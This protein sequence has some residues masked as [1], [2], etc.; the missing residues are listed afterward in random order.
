MFVLGRSTLLCV[1]FTY[2]VKLQAQPPV[3]TSIHSSESHSSESYSS[4]SHSSRSRSSGSGIPGGRIL[5]FNVEWRD[6]TIPI[7]LHDSSSV[8]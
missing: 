2:S 6:R 4:E 5:Q 8:G 7:T 1:L 3:I